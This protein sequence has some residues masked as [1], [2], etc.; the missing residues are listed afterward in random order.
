MEIQ[1]AKRLV[2]VAMATGRPA[3]GFFRMSLVLALAACWISA[4]EA[5]VNTFYKGTA[6]STDSN[7]TMTATVGNPSEP[8]A[9]T[10]AIAPQASGASTSYQDTLFTV[11]S[12]TYTVSV[13]NLRARSWNVTS[14][15]AIVIQASGSTS[16]PKLF[17]G[18]V[19][20]YSG[21]VA[22]QT[23]SNTA[24]FV[25]G[26]SGGTNDA[27]YLSNN[28]SLTFSSVNNTGGSGTATAQLNTGTV[29]IVN[30]NVAVGSTF[31]SD[32]V[33]TGMSGNSA[34]SGITVK[35]GGLVV[36]NAANTYG[37]V[38][39]INS[40]VLSTDSIASGGVNSGIGSSSNTATNL[41]IDGGTL[42]YTGTGATTSRK[43]VV[44]VNG[45]TIENSGAGS[46]GFTSSL[47]L[48]ASGSGSRTLTLTGTSVSNDNVLECGIIDGTGGST[49][50]AKN[51]SGN[52]SLTQIL[53][54]SSTYTGNTTINAGIL[55][56]KPPVA[57]GTVVALS[58][59][60]LVFNGGGLSASSSS[61]ATVPN[62]VRVTT[63]FGLGGI[64]VGNLTLSGSVDL[65]GATRV[66]TMTNNSHTIS[67]LISNGGLT[68]ASTNSA[69]TLTL[70]GVNTYAGNTTVNGGVLKAGG[71]NGFGTGSVTVNAQGTL[72]LN[73][74]AVANAITNNGGTILNS[75]SYAGTQ[76]LLG[77]STFSSLA[78]TLNVGSG[79]KAT[80]NGSI[81]A[82]ITTLAGGTAELASGGSLTQGSVANAGKF[83]FSGT[84]DTILSTAFSGAGSFQK[85]AASIL[86]LS[87]SSFFGAGTQITAGG[88]LVT[89][90]IGGGLVDVS[91]AASI[92]GTG[93]IGGNLNLQSGAYFKFA[94]GNTLVVT[95]SA[96]FGG[97]GV[98]NIDGLSSSTPDG[99]YTLISGLVNFANVSN[100]G[101]SNAYSLGGNKSAYL[102]Q[103]SMDLVVVPEPSAVALAAGGLA[104]VML[105]IRRKTKV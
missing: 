71:V 77:S 16:N 74:L 26:V 72:D 84:T 102:Q 93:R 49:S 57:G 50:V 46:L 91:S 90:S 55:G 68:V 33:I 3:A 39:T 88:L 53:S 40:G 64:G 7:W 28:S 45:A 6:L 48:G 43:F 30:F 85:D 104:A 98:A 105:A 86:S 56:V 22:T 76:S 31:R 27:V 19:A 42:R 8:T 78:G 70:S 81:A 52:W 51:G 29:A 82:T 44:G 25:N 67:G 15:S 99:T 35:G 66:L 38:T 2:G 4:A 17:L 14:G 100:V 61:D 94:P 21:T 89:G 103:G 59:G 1:G 34:S 41:V 54:G 10:Y 5:A 60:T 69:R 79:G 75:G 92:G 32:V 37:G 83:I 47:P 62:N 9:G 23:I 58:S 80:L 20:T 63:D 12:G 18:S 13:S 96:T 95:G 101:A 73:S 36:L 11:A 65:T 24:S 97:F 87:G